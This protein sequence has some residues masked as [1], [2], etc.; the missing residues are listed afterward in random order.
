[1]EIAYERQHLHKLFWTARTVSIGDSHNLMGQNEG[2]VKSRVST[3]APM[4]PPVAAA[5]V[6]DKEKS[7]AVVLFGTVTPLA[8]VP[9]IPVL[10]V[11]EWEQN[12]TLRLTRSDNVPPHHQGVGAVALHLDARGFGVART[13][14]L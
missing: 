2:F 5:R 9:N 14:R 7:V 8:W 4:R 10:A 12:L 6:D 13:Q 11:P 1:M 3:A